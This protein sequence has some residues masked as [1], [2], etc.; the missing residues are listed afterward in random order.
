M[1]QLGNGLF[2]AKDYED[3]LSVKEAELA[4]DR[5]LDA[6]EF[7]I[8]ATQSN[9]AG[10]YG[11]LGRLEEANRIVRDVYSGYS[12][13]LGEEHE[14]TLTTANNYASSL[15]GLQRFKEAKALLR[16]TMP[17]ARRAVGE[18]HRLTLKM[19]WSYAQTLYKDPSATLDD[20]REAVTKLEDTERIARRVLGS[21]HPDVAGIERALRNARAVLRSRTE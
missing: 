12:K 3:A 9:L 4:M 20:L 2:S 1:T 17:V 13:I 5:R 14:V 6:S 15:N 10:T 18:G 7:D 16:R 19:R 8:L 21:A 11:R